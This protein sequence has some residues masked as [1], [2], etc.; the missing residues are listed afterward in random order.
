MA[1]NP[2][3]PLQALSSSPWHRLSVHQAHSRQQHQ[4]RPRSVETTRGLLDSEP[5]AGGSTVEGLATAV[6]H[7]KGLL[8]EEAA[9]LMEEGAALVATLGQ[10]EAEG[11]ARS[12]Q[13]SMATIREQ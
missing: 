6:T 7:S 11:S 4:L 9:H 8:A 3:R 10:M 2:T 1:H 13:A 12:L 5:I